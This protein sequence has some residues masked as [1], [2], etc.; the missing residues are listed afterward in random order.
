[1][2]TPTP[3]LDELRHRLDAIDDRIHDAIMERAGVVE[4]IASLKQSTGQPPFRPGRVAE[5]LR[6]QVARHA[7]SFPRQSLVRLWCE[8]LGGAVSMQG[9]FA[10]AVSEARPGVW[11]IARD[12]FGGHVPMSPLRSAAEVLSAVGDGRAAV[13][14]L[15]MPSDKEDAPW[16]PALAGARGQGPRVIA[17]LPFA[18]G[19]N[20]RNSGDALVIG[21]GPADSTGAD[22]TMVVVET[23]RET[24]RA[25]FIAA[26]EEIGPGVAYLA[27]HAPAPPECWHLLEFD[28]QFAAHDPRFALAL[29]SLGEPAA[30]AWLFGSYARPLPRETK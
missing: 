18:N 11:D 2:D 16:W 19:G 5:I 25:R 26:F 3:T 30:E 21:S 6:R 1:M 8:I 15:P 28:G 29:R 7:G 12:Y 22:R 9:P 13:G 23:R 20:A 10:V 4:S 27:A 24:S 17:R 14:V